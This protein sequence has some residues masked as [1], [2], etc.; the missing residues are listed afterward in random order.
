MQNP[1]PTLKLRRYVMAAALLLVAAA[2]AG[3]ALLV[4]P[5]KL[6]GSGQALVGG[7]FTMVNQRA[8]TVTE[9][10]FGGHPL[11]LFFGFTFCPDVCPTELQVITQALDDLGDQGKDITPLFV[12][13]DPDRDTPQVLASY[14]SNFSDRIIGLT[15]SPEQVAAMANTYRVFYAKQPPE[16]DG[17]YE[18]DHSSIIYLMGGDGKF[19]KHFSYTTDA[20][21]LAQGI[22]TALGR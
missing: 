9:K 18:M 7:S 6:P 4:D 14:L 3:A 19:L 12:S 11:L 8:E 1:V 20:K 16:K 21:A 5:A 2:L 17:S 22:R 13:I 10:S 15:G